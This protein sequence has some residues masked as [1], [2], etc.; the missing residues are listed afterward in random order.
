MNIQWKKKKLPVIVNK[1]MKIMQAKTQKSLLQHD[2]M[3]PLMK[4]IPQ[5][6]TIYIV[7]Q[8]WAYHCPSQANYS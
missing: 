7:Q 4:W 8:F 3:W 2:K 6:K 5:K 1:H